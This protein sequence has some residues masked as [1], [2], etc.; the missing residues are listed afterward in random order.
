MKNHLQILASCGW[1]KVHL[2]IGLCLYL[3]FFSTCFY[4]SSHY[5]FN[6]C[7]LLFPLD[8]NWEGVLVF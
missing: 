7:V 4:L 6:S 5:F 3:I 1:G 2:T 8:G